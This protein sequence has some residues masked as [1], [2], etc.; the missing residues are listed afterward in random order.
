[1]KK[2]V[3]YKI[4]CFSVTDNLKGFSEAIQAV[5]PKTEIQ[6]CVIHQIRNSVRFVGYIDLK[7]ITCDL[8]PIYKANTEEM[9]LVAL[10]DFKKKMG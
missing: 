3:A 1:M 6:K 2:I 9:A 5:F 4:F 8:K 10:E 7:V